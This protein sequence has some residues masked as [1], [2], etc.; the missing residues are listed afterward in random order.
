MTYLTI[1]EA[2][3][4]ASRVKG[5]TVEPATLLRAAIHGVLPITAT[6]NGLMRN[7]TAHT[8]DDYAGL[9]ILAPRDL[10]T[11]ET[12]G[13][14]TIEGAFSL[15]G[16]TAYS[17]QVQR[18]LDQLRVMV[19]HLDKFLPLLESRDTQT[20][21]AATPAAKTVTK[22]ALPWWQQDYDILLQAQNAGDSLRRQNKKTSNRAIG[23]KIALHITQEELR[24]KKR[25]APSGE[26]IKNTVLKGWK[27]TAD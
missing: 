22:K 7:L 15:D 23:D 19:P 24:D 17:P 26:T 14:A 5:F 4:Y 6:F 20:T 16:E 13:Q 12:E 9:L 27:Y 25:K 8:N 2:A 18:T 3:N 1:Q 10:M 11:I 21:S